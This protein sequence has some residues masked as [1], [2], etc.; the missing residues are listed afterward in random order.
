M[1]QI[2]DIKMGTVMKVDN[3]PYVVI[4][5]QQ[6]HM[7]R[8]GSILRFKIKNLVTGI[9]LEKTFKGTDKAEEADLERGKASYLYKDENAAYFM[10]TQ[11]YEQ[12][13]LGLDVSA[14]KVGYLKEGVE[15][16]VLYF[17]DRPVSIDIPKKI[18]LQVTDTVDGARG[19][20][21]QGKVLKPAVVET[22]LT[23]NVPLFVKQGDLIRINTETNDYLERVSE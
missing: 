16:D 9:V 19:D 18:V 12:F 4:Y 3:Q 5:T 2:S 14:E 7:G 11:T 13:D 22:G 17:E 10:N 8:G 1:L 23:V 21:A 20:T 15:V 6:V